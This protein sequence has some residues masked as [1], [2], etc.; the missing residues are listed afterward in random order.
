MRPKGE[1]ALQAGI[2]K[3]YDNLFLF[4]NAGSVSN[5]FEERQSQIKIN[6]H[7][8]RV[9]CDNNKMIDKFIFN[10]QATEIL[11]ACALYDNN[12]STVFNLYFLVLRQPDSEK[13][14]LIL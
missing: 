9:S 12:Q 5:Y 13:R 7:S 11:V 2:Y 1:V 3:V 6:S 10:A 8:L 14:N 4:L